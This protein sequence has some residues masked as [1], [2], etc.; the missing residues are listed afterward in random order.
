[1]GNA[2]ELGGGGHNGYFM[3]RTSAL[4]KIPLRFCP[5][6][7]RFWGI[8]VP[9]SV[10]IMPNACAQV[11]SMRH[12]MATMAATHS[13]SVAPLDDHFMIRTVEERKIYVG[14][15]QSPLRVL[16]MINHLVECADMPLSAHVG[17]AQRKI[18]PSC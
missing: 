8:S 11:A 18:W 1:M 17:G 2:T 9:A 12:E 15:S 5:F 7:I 16:I 4:T 13:K 3:I 6:P 10:L 14:E